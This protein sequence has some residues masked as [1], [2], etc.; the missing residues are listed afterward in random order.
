M[1]LYCYYQVGVIVPLQQQERTH[2][3]LWKDSHNN[4]QQKDVKDRVGI[5]DHCGVH[6]GLGALNAYFVLPRNC[7]VQPAVTPIS[8]EYIT[9]GM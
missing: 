2:M 6:R 1:P 8:D 7:I 3:L 9:A 4:M 5:E